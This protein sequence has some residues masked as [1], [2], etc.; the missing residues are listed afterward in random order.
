M[1]QPRLVI[2][3]SVLLLAFLSP[4]AFAQSAFDTWFNCGKPPAPGAVAPSLTP[5]PPPKPAGG[6]TDTIF[7]RL[8]SCNIGLHSKINEETQGASFGYTEAGAGSKQNGFQSQ[9][10]LVWRPAPY[11]LSDDTSLFP[12]WSVDGNLATQSARK[13]NFLNIRPEFGLR[14]VEYTSAGNQNPVGLGSLSGEFIRFGPFY[15][16]NQDFSVQNLMAEV[17]ATYTQLSGPLRI[18]QYMPLTSDLLWRFR[19]YLTVQAGQSVTGL[20]LSREFDRTRLR[21]IADPI[22][23]IA[24]SDNLAK[25]LGLTTAVFRAEEVFTVL[26]LE[27]RTLT[28][29][30]SVLHSDNTHSQLS[31]SFDMSLGKNFSFGPSYSTG[32]VA[33]NFVRTHVFMVSLKVGF[34]PG[35]SGETLF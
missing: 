2:C 26:P 11:S 1:K 25:S 32:D 8:A 31:L 18:G 21:L 16:A 29:G 4:S 6:S 15:E 10:A 27:G 23:E 7:D 5:T 28:V 35:G 19:P 22:V 30:K 14:H 13:D 17:S 33:P 34:G 3:T 12:L 20:A 9:F 24:A